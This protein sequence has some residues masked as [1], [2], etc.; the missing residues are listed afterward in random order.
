[1]K[2][3]EL[4]TLGMTN[5]GDEVTYTCAPVGSGVRMALDRNENGILDLDE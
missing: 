1:M 5:A 3:A 4:R 2:D